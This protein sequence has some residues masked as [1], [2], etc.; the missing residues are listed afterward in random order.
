MR[1]EILAGLSTFFT[2]AYLILLYP[3]ILAEGGID[4]GSALTATILTIVFS[5]TFLALYA[6]FPAVLAPGLSI[7]PYLVYSVILQQHAT[8][9]TVFG[10]V[11]WAGLVLLLLS[12]FKV[13]Q[14]ILLHM[15]SS[16]KSAAIAGIGLFLICIG[17]K[18]LSLFRGEI[19]TI[20]NG[21]VLFGLLLFFALYYFQISSAFLLSIVACWALAFP[22]GLAAWKGVAALPASLTPTFLQLDFWTPLHPQMWGTLLSV[23]LINLFDT[24]ASLSILAKLA[25]KLDEEGRIKNLDRIVIPDGVGN[26][27]AS[28]LSLP[29]SR[30]ISTCATQFLEK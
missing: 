24:S 17:L 10:I 20:P 1:K 26:I 9:Q 25:H 13:R 11:F 30:R 8:W 27:F 29:L 7:G 22:F 15:P 2:V 18:D 21:I 19:L 6:H 28:F 14:Q 16:I 23:I 12:L 4:F 3:K 5:T